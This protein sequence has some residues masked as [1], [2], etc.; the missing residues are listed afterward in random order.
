MVSA[1]LFAMADSCRLIEQDAAVNQQSLNFRFRFFLVDNF[2][3]GLNS[4]MKAFLNKLRELSLGKACRL[5]CGF[6]RQRLQSGD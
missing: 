1:S 4:D 5:C 2:M 3:L 6:L